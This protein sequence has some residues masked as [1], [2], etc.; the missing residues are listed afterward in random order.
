MTAAAAANASRDVTAF[1]E[2]LLLLPF[3]AIADLLQK[4]I[5]IAA[6]ADSIEDEVAQIFTIQLRSLFRNARQLRFLSALT[7]G[8]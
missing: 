7:R 1:I 8:R 6:V 5:D 3:E 2:Q 4:L